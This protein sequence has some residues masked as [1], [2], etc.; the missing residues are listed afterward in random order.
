MTEGEIKFILR[1]LNLTVVGSRIQ[2]IRLSDCSFFKD[3]KRLI[4]SF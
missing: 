2:E 3:F 4:A 1:D